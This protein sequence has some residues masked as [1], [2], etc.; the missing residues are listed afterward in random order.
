MEST[1]QIRGGAKAAAV[2]QKLGLSAASEV[3]KR[4]SP[5]E[6][7]ELAAGFLAIDRMKPGERQRLVETCLSEFTSS[8]QQVTGP[9]EFARELLGNSLVSGTN[10][11]AAP[12][13]G[14]STLALHWI[15]DSA[16]EAIEDLL[17]EESS[18][19]G[20][21]VLAAI[22]P[23][24]AARVLPLLTE[25]RRGEILLALAQ[26][27]LPT[28]EAAAAILKRVGE[29]VAQLEE[30]R[31]GAS[32]GELAG[33]R[34]GVPRTVEILR[35]CDRT[36]ERTAVAHLEQLE[37]GLAEQISQGIFS[38]IQDMKWLEKRALQMVLREIEMKDLGLALRGVP[39]EIRELCFAN[40]SANVAADLKEELETSSPRPRRDVETAQETVLTTI[41]AMIEDGR[42]DLTSE[43]DMI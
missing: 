3:V 7:E 36:T 16:A 24:V 19:I 40:L 35:Q 23:T 42:I 8:G 33:L 10:G 5:A 28:A 26:G 38:S 2:L 1:T 15:G 27:R 30:K 20:A 13:G 25:E 31:R 29:L 21:V 11:S 34:M 41:R 39:E 32:G 12:A 6:V 43:E 18:R 9:R 22:R 17:A 4:L 37:P 14:Q